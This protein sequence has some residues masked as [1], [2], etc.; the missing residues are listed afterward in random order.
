MSEDALQ[1]KIANDPRFRKQLASSSLAWFATIYLGH[2]IKEDCPQFHFD[3]YDT[4]NALP[5]GLTEIV[6]FRG[7]G[8]STIAA[9]ALPLWAA[10]TGKRK[11]IVLVSDTYTQAKL[12][13]SHLQNEVENNAKLKEDFG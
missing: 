1:Q 4:L 8:K 10:Y 9:L 7:S 12:L 5:S 3:I 6:A 13:I 2:Y 11:F